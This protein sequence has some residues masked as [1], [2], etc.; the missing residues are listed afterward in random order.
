MTFTAT[1]TTL[2]ATRGEA[3]R[4]ATASV[5]ATNSGAAHPTG[6]VAPV[7]KI[8]PFSLVDG[9]GSRTAVFLQGCNIRCA[10]CH[11]PETQVECISCQA[12]VKPCPAHALSVAD[13][14]VV[15]DNS[16][17]INCDNCIKVCQHKSTPK[18][19]LLSAREVADRCISNMP[20]IRGITTSGGECML[21]PDFL[22]EL[23]TYCNAAGLSC[24]IDSNGTI[25]F[26]EYRDLLD[27][28]SGVMLD[29]KAWD[30]QWFEHLTGENGVTV[31]KNLAF[32]AEQNKLE[33]VRVI[34]TEGWNDAEAAVDG[35]ASTLGEKV[36]Q[37]RIR[38]MK[39]RRF[40]VRGPMENSPSPSD[41]RMQAIELQARSLGFGEVVVS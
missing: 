21:R 39:F 2:G 25:D 11:N 28:S 14:K 12:C 31:R 6:C 9:P 3:A 20:F 38:L 4:P 24:L 29:V 40:G 13:G 27:L 16:I 10:Y 5:P 36:G 33:E 17:C 41:E 35:I 23:F 34:V 8:I 15:W 26:T 7:N 22:Y 18:I 37:T 32:L 19:E 30:D 1:E